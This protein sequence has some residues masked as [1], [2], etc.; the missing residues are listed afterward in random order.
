MRVDDAY[1]VLRLPR[2]ADEDEV[3]RAYRKLALQH[4]PDKNPGDATATA[5]WRPI[6]SRRQANGGRWARTRRRVS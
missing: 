5:T 6:S 4:H 3:K 2:R 1:A